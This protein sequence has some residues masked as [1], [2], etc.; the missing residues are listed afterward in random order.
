M[1]GR[2]VGIAAASLAALIGATF[3]TAQIA[4]LRLNFT[5]S[6]PAGLWRVTDAK[7]DDLK[8]GELVEV[9]PPVRPIVSLMADR[10]YLEPGD[11]GP[12][13]LTPLL[14][15]LAAVPGDTVTISEGQPVKVNGVAL[16][17]TEAMPTLPAWPEGT[18][19]VEKGQVWLFSTFS[20]GSFDSR[21]FGP[22]AIT[23]IRGSAAPLL[24]SGDVTGMTLT[25]G[26]HD[27]GRY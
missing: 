22:V 19:H 6:A 16:M 9:C 2:S 17:N 25:T 4:G 8:R 13:H 12:D 7:T 10:G 24:V 23:N 15:P 20:A 14:K 1:K 11:C 26:G 21:Y 5:H 3:V 27:Y 18:Y